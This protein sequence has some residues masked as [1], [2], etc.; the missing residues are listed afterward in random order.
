MQRREMLDQLLDL[1]PR[2]RRTDLPV[3]RDY[4]VSGL[5]RIN[6]GTGNTGEHVLNGG[7]PPDRCADD[8]RL[9]TECVRDRRWRNLTD[10]NWCRHRFSTVQAKRTAAHAMRS[11]RRAASQRRLLQPVL[12]SP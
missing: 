11:A 9:A 7:V 6:R 3:V 12:R 2:G 1:L 10:C 5:T 8:K 4:V